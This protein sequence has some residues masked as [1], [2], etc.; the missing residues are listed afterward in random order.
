MNM[1]KGRL[2]ERRRNAAIMKLAAA[3]RTHDQ[4]LTRLNNGGYMAVRERARL[5]EKARKEA[6][7]THGS[8][9]E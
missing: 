9:D 7:R 1:H 5:L 3:H 6:R 8:D 2:E 4:K